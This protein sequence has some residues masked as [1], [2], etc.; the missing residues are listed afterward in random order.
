MPGQ[1]RPDQKL[2][3]VAAKILKKNKDRL[4]KNEDRP[5]DKRIERWRVD[6][7]SVVPK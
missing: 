7:S 4:Q 5:S 2:V 3:K 6:S 1:I